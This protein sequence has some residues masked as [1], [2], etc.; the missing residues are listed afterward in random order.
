[1][2]M[3]LAVCVLTSIYHHKPGRKYEP[4]NA[5]NNSWERGNHQI[6][7][8]VIRVGTNQMLTDERIGQ[9]AKA[10]CND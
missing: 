8:G 5:E 2:D 9:K 6:A 7:L 10:Q 4:K 3:E 1:M